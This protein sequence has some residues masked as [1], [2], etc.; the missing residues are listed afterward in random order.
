MKQIK[1]NVTIV[2]STLIELDDK[3]IDFNGI[4]N[5][6]LINGVDVLKSMVIAQESAKRCL[7]F[8]PEN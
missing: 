8:Y 3:Y 5:E 1:R 7:V 6:T 2:S 4:N